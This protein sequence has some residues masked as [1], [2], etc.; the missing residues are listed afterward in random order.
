MMDDLIHTKQVWTWRNP[1]KL[2]SSRWKH[3]YWYK[4][5]FLETWQIAYRVSVGKAL[6][7]Y[8]KT[9]QFLEKESG[10]HQ[11]LWIFHRNKIFLHL[12]CLNLDNLH[13]SWRFGTHQFKILAEPLTYSPQELRTAC[14]S[15]LK[16]MHSNSDEFSPF[17]TFLST[18]LSY[19][20]DFAHSCLKFNWGKKI[21]QKECHYLLH[22]LVLFQNTYKM[23]SWKG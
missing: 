12:T 20:H 7:G 15:I 8:S 4:S 11:L 22:H 1:M 23:P 2:A 9:C 14:L 19:I 6:R 17:L 3:S 5:C 16:M 13:L 10:T 21:R 18:R